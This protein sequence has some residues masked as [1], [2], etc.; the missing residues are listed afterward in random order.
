MIAC[1][2]R[3]CTCFGGVL[4]SPTYVKKYKPFFFSSFISEQQSVR[5]DEVFRSVHD[6]LKRGDKD[7]QMTSELSAATMPLADHRIDC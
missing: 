5:R 2:E 4:P 1:S 7:L 3:K 6:C